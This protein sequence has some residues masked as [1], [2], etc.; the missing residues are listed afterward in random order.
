MA[1]VMTTGGAGRYWEFPAWVAVRV[2]SPD[3]PVG[4]SVSPASVTGPESSVSVTGSPLDEET[5][6]ANAGLRVDRGPGGTYEMVC[7][8]SGAKWAMIALLESI[9]T[10]RVGCGL[11]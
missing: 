5:D 3:T 1:N 6:R 4:V 7:A 9:R 11:V 8:R 2:T 10:E